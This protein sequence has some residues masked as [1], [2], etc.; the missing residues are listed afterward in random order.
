M[1]PISYVVLTI[2]YIIL[3]W[4]LPSFNVTSIRKYPLDYLKT[5]L[6]LHLFLAAIVLILWGLKSSP[7]VQSWLHLAP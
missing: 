5:V 1:R 3:F 6:V 4:C 2:Y 7:I